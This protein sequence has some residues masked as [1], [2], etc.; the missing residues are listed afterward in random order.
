[1]KK[2]CIFIGPS[3]ALDAA[4]ERCSNALWLPPAEQGS[5]VAAI[6]YHDP[7]II[8]I[9]DG[10]FRHR[11]AV[12]HK[13]I[14][15]ALSRG[16][17][18]FG[19]ASM[20]ALRAAE[21]APYG[22]QGFGAI[23]SAYR[24]GALP[25]FDGLTDDDEVAVVHGPAETGFLVGSDALVNIRSTLRAAHDENIIDSALHDTLLSIARS[26]PF[27][28]RRY[29]NVMATARSSASS[30]ELQYLDKLETW[31]P[32]GRIDQKAVD[33]KA[34]IDAVTHWQHH[35]GTPHQPTFKLAEPEL[36]HTHLAHGADEHLVEPIPD[37]SASDEGT[38]YTGHA[39]S[40]GAHEREHGV[41][42]LLGKDDAAWQRV[43]DEALVFWLLTDPRAARTE[44]TTHDAPASVNVRSQL[45]DWRQG[46][47][48]FD[49]V[50]IDRWLNE[51][52]LPLQRIDALMAAQVR[53]DAALPPDDDPA[54]R[55]L[56][57]DRLKLSGD[58]ARLA[59]QLTDERP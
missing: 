24:A 22:M 57:L 17:H 49:R 56:M 9:I 6:E 11:A 47:G 8:A 34:V 50:A 18:M 21:L 40:Y 12:W 29:S 54:L 44:I 4:R 20:G 42:A 31:L 15:W 51:N 14:L 38:S 55:R 33:A 30:R 5:V 16:V 35:D 13:E 23:F 32:S 25:P 59:R 3:L 37:F 1:M 46:A 26:T 2:A 39:T 52:D 48:L 53:R 27:A 7:P 58:Y 19:G 10:Y 36:W 43:R 41:L 28:G 45:D